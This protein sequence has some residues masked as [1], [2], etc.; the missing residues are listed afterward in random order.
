MRKCLWMLVVAVSLVGSAYSQRNVSKEF[1]TFI[2]KLDAAQLELQNG[3]AETFK[4]MWSQNDDVTLSGGFGGTIEKG[5]PAISKRLDWVGANFSMGKNSIERLVTDQDGKLGYV[6]QLEH[7]SFIV[8]DTG[9]MATRD[10]RVTM[11]FRREKK[12]WRLVHRQA[13]S[14][15]TKQA[16]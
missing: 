8:P 16:P 6:V 7:I 5:W 1:E 11:I 3:K 12:G 10:Y 2:A 4:A 9:K 15:L 13:D 14:N